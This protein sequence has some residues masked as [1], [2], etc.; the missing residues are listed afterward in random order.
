[1][2]RVLLAHGGGGQLTGELVRQ[3]VL[4]ALRSAQAP[5]SLLDAA[6]LRLSGD[7]AFTTDTYV[8]SPLEFPGGD[9]G[10]L[11]ICGTINDLAV[12]GAA[13]AGISVA[14]VIEEGLPLDLL[15]RVL[16][17][18]GAEAAA[19]G[20]PVVTG[21]TKVVQRGKCDGLFICTAGVG[22]TRPGASL[23]FD[24]VQ[25]DDVLLV[26]G[27]LGEHGLAVMSCRQE[28]SFAGELKSD[29]ASLAGPCLAL[30][31]ELGPSVRFM[32]DLTRGGLSACLC[33]LCAATGRTLQ[34][35]Q[36][37]LPVRAPA[38]AAAELLGLDVMDIANEGCFL[39]V[40]QP[41][42][43]ARALTLLRQFAPC[44]LASAVGVVGQ[45]EQPPLVELL[46]P[47][48]GRRLVQMPYGEELPRIC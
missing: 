44:A 43:A 24:K 22:A 20:A 14:L 38:L 28:L 7:A 30:V 4:P 12:S 37:D 27:P 25:T 47:I 8:V 16:E 1:M 5:A 15:R 48:G 10:K 35:R 31:D 46:T 32:R 26:S 3:I 13:P 2:E 29:C 21:D 17:S 23:G 9:I 6:R 11:A 39:A 40:V 36:R 34:V 19:A 18:A 42:A 45:A 33:D 41:D